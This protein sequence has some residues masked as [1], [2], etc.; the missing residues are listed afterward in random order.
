MAVFRETVPRDLPGKMME[1]NWSLVLLLGLLG[2][3]G[4]AM[5]YSL[6]DLQARKSVNKWHSVDEMVCLV[7]RQTGMRSSQPRL[8]SSQHWDDFSL[9]WHDFGQIIPSSQLYR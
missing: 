7:A 5:L 9:S 2:V 4:V 1:I 8:R 6:A 3:A